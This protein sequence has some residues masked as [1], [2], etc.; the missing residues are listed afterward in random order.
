MTL[1]LATAEDAAIDRVRVRILP[2]GRMSR[3][4]A[5]KYLGRASKTLAQWVVDGKGPRSVC[6]GGRIYYYKSELDDFI[7]GEAARPRR[8]KKPAAA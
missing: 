5:A 7:R 8:K 4:E 3:D 6:I 1:V 2:D